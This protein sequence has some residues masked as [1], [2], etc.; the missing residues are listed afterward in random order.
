M[1][2]EVRP[3]LATPDNEH[4]FRKVLRDNPVGGNIIISMEREPNALFAAGITGDRYDLLMGVRDDIG[5]AVVTGG[6]YELDLFVNGKPQRTGY[7]GE[8]RS[9]G[10]FGFRRKYLLLCYDHRRQPAGASSAGGQPRGHA[11][12]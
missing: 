12:L 5:E 2:V 10:G 1:A 9:T 11:R 7:L 6:R 4:L 8:L 3:V